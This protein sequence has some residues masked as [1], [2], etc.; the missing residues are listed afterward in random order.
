MTSL[1]IKGT[2]TIKRDTVNSLELKLFGDD[3]TDGWM[4]LYKDSPTFWGVMRPNVK[5]V[6]GIEF[7]GLPISD[8]EADDAYTYIIQDTHDY[9]VYRLK[10][11]RPLPSAGADMPF[12]LEVYGKYYRKPDTTDK[13]ACV[14]PSTQM[15]TEWTG[16]DKFVVTQVH[17][18]RDITDNSTHVE[19]RMDERNGYIERTR[20]PQT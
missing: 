19:L 12:E 16:D 13:P 3:G 6:S 8:F 7:G 1:L 9:T 18:D 14:G 15:T 2:Y 11:S 20:V 10:L 4:S 5:G 17:I